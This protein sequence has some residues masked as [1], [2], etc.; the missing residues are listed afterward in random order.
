MPVAPLAHSQL[1]AD[2]GSRPWLL[3]QALRDGTEGPECA[4]P[5]TEGTDLNPATDDQINNEQAG[6]QQQQ[7]QQQ[8]QQQSIGETEL[9][10]ET[11]DVLPEDKF[12]KHDMVSQYIKDER[13]RQRKEKELETTAKEEAKQAQE[14][15]EQA[16]KDEEAMAELVQQARLKLDT[17]GDPA[18]ASGSSAAASL[19]LAGEDDMELM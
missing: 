12:H 2:A 14:A 8:Q 10:D 11:V 3:A 13:E 1:G 7:L 18:S 15:Q 17:E 5:E 4:G 9:E 19:S 16:R 6:Q